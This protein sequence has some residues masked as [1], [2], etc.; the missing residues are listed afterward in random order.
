MQAVLVNIPPSDKKLKEFRNLRKKGFVLDF[1]ELPTNLGI[2]Q[3]VLK[4]A[5]WDT[6]VEDLIFK[7][8][9][10]KNRIEDEIKRISELVKKFDLLVFVSNSPYIKDVLYFFSR[11]KLPQNKPSIL[12][13][14]SLHLKA[15]LKK[16][17]SALK[18]KIIFYADVE[19]PLYYFALLYKYYPDWKSFKKFIPNSIWLSNG[20]TFR[21]KVIR[22]DLDDIPLPDFT[23]IRID[24]YL[25][26]NPILP[27]FF[28]RGCIFRCAH[29]PA[30]RIFGEWRGMSK[31]KIREVC[32]HLREM[33]KNK[34]FKVLLADNMLLADRNWFADL[35]EE[36]REN[37][38]SWL[39]SLRPDMIDEKIVELLSKSGCREVTL[40][41]DVICDWNPK[42]AKEIG[43]IYRLKQ[44]V[45]VVELLKH[46]GIKVNVYMI[47]EM[48]EPNFEDKLKKI[49]EL[50]SPNKI[51]IS[52]LRKY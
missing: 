15:S 37:E 47:K 36:L 49:N 45:K 13:G 27:F 1:P 38:L 25:K 18:N 52:S 31:E 40:G 9:F 4:K 14:K 30:W 51:L 26:E 41:L 34:R 3:A 46:A 44:V 48:Y 35:C 10:K 12:I 6:Q 7:V 32:K 39:C 11:I 43:K 33:S 21:G 50:M 23:G 22:M 16:P 2:Y 5:G 8:W 28:S 17:E 42:K 24:R 19:L 29:C 20:K